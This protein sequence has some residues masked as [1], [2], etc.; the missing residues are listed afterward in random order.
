MRS[1]LFVPTGSERVIANAL[2]SDADALVFDFED[3]IA[4]AD[5]G[6]VRRAAVRAPAR[7]LRAEA[8]G[9]S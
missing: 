9:A 5:K 6:D 7:R 3:V 4:P 8:G 1:L 2:V